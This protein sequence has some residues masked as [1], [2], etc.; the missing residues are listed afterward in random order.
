MSENLPEIDDREMVNM[1]AAQSVIMDHRDELEDEYMEYV[2]KY[3][4]KYDVDEA[5]GQV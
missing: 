5:K 4:E 3:A 1:M 2:R